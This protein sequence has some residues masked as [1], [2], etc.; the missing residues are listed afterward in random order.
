MDMQMFDKGFWHNMSAKELA[1][2][3]GLAVEREAVG[4]VTVLEVE[5]V[6]KPSGRRMRRSTHQ[7]FTGFGRRI[8]SP[9]YVST[10]RI[11]AVQPWDWAGECK[12]TTA[13]CES[14]LSYGP[15]CKVVA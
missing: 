15:W 3:F 5:E 6:V 9:A 8:P 13:F 1:R 10:L 2:E 11:P 4:I 14:S 12:W 7:M